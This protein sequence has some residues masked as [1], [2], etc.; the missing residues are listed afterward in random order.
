[1]SHLSIKH[2]HFAL[3]ICYMLKYGGTFT[4]NITM[5]AASIDLGTN[6]LKFTNPSSVGRITTPAILE[7]LD[8]GY[9]TWI[10]VTPTI[11]PATTFSGNITKTISQTVLETLYSGSSTWLG[12]TPPLSQHPP[13]SQ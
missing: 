5:S 11:L 12:V 9:K 10:S 8:N 6:S 1:M 7:A 3:T 13:L 2:R 4:V